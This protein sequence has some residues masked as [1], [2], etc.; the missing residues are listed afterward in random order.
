MKPI[1]KNLDVAQIFKAAHTQNLI[2]SYFIE[3]FILGTDYAAEINVF[4]IKGRYAVLMQDFE[5]LSFDILFFEKQP[6]SKKI[7]KLGYKMFSKYLLSQ[8]ILLFSNQLKIQ[9]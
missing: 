6:S 8:N 2:G 3:T 4:S 9:I 7:K 1:A 5:C